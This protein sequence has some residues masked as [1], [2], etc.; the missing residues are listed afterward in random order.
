MSLRLFG[1]WRSSAT[2]RVRIA[3]ELK[4]LAYDYEPVNLLKGEQ[5]SGE[6]MKRNPQG[7]VP[8]LVTEEGETITQSQA[9]IEYLEERYPEH[10]VL[11]ADAA[12][13]A[14]ARA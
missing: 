8:T 1:Y 9:I 5:I 12:E 2:Y 4:K 14:K 7:L 10:R 13:R 6:Y 3:L 11:P